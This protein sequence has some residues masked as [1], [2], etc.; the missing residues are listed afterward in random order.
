MSESQPL[1]RRLLARIGLER[2]PPGLVTRVADGLAAWW[3]P[4]LL[5]FGALLY[6][7]LLEAR[8]LRFEE[9]RRA[10]QALEI[11]A[12]ESWWYLRVLGEP[13]VNKPPLLPW[14]ITL[15]GYLRGGIDEFTVRLP[16]VLS[17]LLGAATAGGLALV[18]A[19]SLVPEQ[20][21]LAALAAGLAFY[22]CAFVMTKARL[23]ETDTLVTAFCGLAFLIWARARLQGSI[24]IWAWAG[25]C[26]WLAAASFTKGPVPVVFPALAFL[27][28]PLWQRRWAEAAIALGVILLSFLPLGWWAFDNLAS[29]SAAHWTQEMRVAGRS[30]PEGYW[31]S[32]LHLNQVPTAVAYTLPWCLPALGLLLAARRGEVRPGW[33]Y[34]GLALFA[35]PM[36]LFVLIWGEARPRYAMPAVWPIMV[37]AGVWV[38]WRWTRSLVPALFLLGGFITVVTFQVISLTAVEGKTNFQREFRERAESLGQ[39]VED[40]PPGPILLLDSSGEPDFDSLAYAMRPLT[41]LRLAQ[42]ECSAPSP[43]LVVAKRDLGQIAE[44]PLWQEQQLIAGG[45]MAL[46]QRDEAACPQ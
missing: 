41:R 27:A 24:G 12:G 44:N 8:P 35:I 2:A 14:L 43:H 36:A 9:G 42:L 15:V 21:R 23:G 17:V 19:R 16:A 20:R 10:V 13:Y 11:Y 28:V 25:I 46:Y 30:L 34:L 33:V 6:L 7:P 38:A 4:L 22:S 1:V 18:L 31:L 5:V 26:L 45:W 3:L 40:L 37:L 32:L 29:T 39:A